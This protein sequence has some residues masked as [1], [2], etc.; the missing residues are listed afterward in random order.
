MYANY[1]EYIAMLWRNSKIPFLPILSAVCSFQ[2]Q[3]DRATAAVERSVGISKER[4]E[5]SGVCFPRSLFSLLQKKEIEWVMTKPFVIKVG[6]IREH[7]GVSSWARDLSSENMLASSVRWILEPWETV[8]WLNWGLQFRMDEN[9][10]HLKE[11]SIF[12]LQ[13]TVLPHSR[14]MPIKLHSAWV[15]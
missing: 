10:I 5:G 13:Q 2:R 14:P 3:R 7:S 6:T 11:E 9:L 8:I 15:T 12:C 4:E 1:Y